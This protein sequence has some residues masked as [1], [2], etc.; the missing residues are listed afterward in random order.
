MI[1]LHTRTILS[2]GSCN[3]AA[4]IRQA[5]LVG[6]RLLGL[7]DQADF[8]TL[9]FILPPLLEAAKRENE[10]DYLKI[11]VGVEL[12]FVRPEQIKEAT[13]LARKLGAQIV[14]VHGEGDDSV[15]VGSNRAAIGAGV[16]ILA[17]PGKISTE[18]AAYAA[19]ENVLLEIS[20]RAGDQAANRAVVQAAQASGAGLIFGS[21]AYSPATLYN[22][23]RALAV[24]GEAGLTEEESAAIFNNAEQFARHKAMQQEMDTTDDW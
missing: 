10:L 6:I 8:A 20:G 17:H 4:M 11:I 16:D 19:R 14:L 15:Q 3:P 7:T 18:G 5:E 2:G 21:A 23:E 22:R 13:V 1:D 24:C 9:P 12:T